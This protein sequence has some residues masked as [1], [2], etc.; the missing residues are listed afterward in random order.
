M[1]KEKKRR[2]TSEEKAKLIAACQSSNLSNEAWCKAQNIGVSTFYKWCQK[3]ITAQPKTQQW[4]PVTTAT[5]IAKG[6]TNEIAS[7]AITL[8][9]GK[10]TLEVV[11]DTDKQLLMDTLKMLVAIC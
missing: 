6:R 3:T 1:E 4:M 8:Q 11:A 10:C 7:A 2:Y 9:I 5:A